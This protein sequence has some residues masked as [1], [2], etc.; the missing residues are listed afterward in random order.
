MYSI[1]YLNSCKVY[2]LMKTDVKEWDAEILFDLLSPTEAHIIMQIPLTSNSLEDNWYW[3]KEPT[4]FYSVKSAYMHLQAMKDNLSTHNSSAFWKNF[5]KIKVPPK[6][7][8]FAWRVLTDCLAT[9]VQLQIRRVPVQSH[10]LFCNS[11]A[12]TSFHLFIECPFSKSCWNISAVTIPSTTAASFLDWFTAVSDRYKGDAIEEVLMVSWS[13]WKAR[14]NI[15][16]NNKTTTA[17]EV[18]FTA[19]QVLDQ[20]KHAQSCRFEPLHLS[21][22]I[23]SSSDNWT[24]PVEGTIKIN[25]DGATFEANNSYGTGFIVRDTNGAV[26]FA[27]SLHS[28]G[29]SNAPF[30][31][32]ISIKE[33]LSWI[34]A[35][36]LTERISIE[37]DCLT[38]VQALNCQLDMPSLFGAIVQEC[39][40]F[41]SLLSN[42]SI[43]HV[44]RSA[45]KAA[46]CL[47]RGSCYWSGRHFNEST[48][49]STLKSFVIA[50]LV[51]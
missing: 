37:T 8:H 44:K 42:V 11:A 21:S 39:R 26:M 48:L 1:E 30:A 51:C 16:W 38:A 12:E 3:N 4:G 27:T 40:S 25:V 24:K 29:L 36:D 2:Q 46:H 34:K 13:I 18:V 6:V 47:A 22:N 9:R 33:A 10:C 32:M 20:W 23:S 31:E 19:H 45:N 49:P 7:L 43:C 17:A 14:N 28:M 50:D 41:L 15:V 35:S 5:W